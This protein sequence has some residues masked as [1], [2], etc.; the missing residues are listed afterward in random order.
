MLNVLSRSA[1]FSVLGQGS[2]SGPPG[3]QQHT[4]HSLY[5]TFITHFLS[6][7][8]P[9]GLSSAPAQYGGVLLQVGQVKYLSHV[10]MDLVRTKSFEE[11]LID[12][13]GV[14]LTPKQCE[15]FKDALGS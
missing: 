12:A 10:W 3:G 15:V 9:F 11:H 13:C 2:S 5:Y 4:T 7:C 1:W 14:K 6:G 8:V